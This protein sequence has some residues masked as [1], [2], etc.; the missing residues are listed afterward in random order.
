MSFTLKQWRKL[1]GFNAQYVSS[2]LGISY[3]TFKRYEELPKTIP[4]GKMFL[5]N[6]LYNIDISDI[7]FG[8]SEVRS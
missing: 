5:I 7:D 6:E 1:R 8:E 3:P 4:I 2:Y